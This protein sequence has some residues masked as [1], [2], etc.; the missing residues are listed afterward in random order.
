[1]AV[2]GRP[3]PAYD[4]ALVPCVVAAEPGAAL[5]Q[6]ILEA[7][8]LKLSKFKQPRQ[9]VFLED[10][11][12]EL[13]DKIPKRELRQQVLALEKRKAEF[14]L[15]INYTFGDRRSVPPAI[16]TDVPCPRRRA[17]SRW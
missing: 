1:M 10:L 17:G 9:V 3:D 12:K 13:L 11:R 14:A 15:Q 4:E 2:V 16:L 6:E 7:C 5:E 8:R